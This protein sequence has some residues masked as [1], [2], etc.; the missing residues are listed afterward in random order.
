MLANAPQARCRMPTS[1]GGAAAAAA[2]SASLGVPGVDLRCAGRQ[3]EMGDAPPSLIL[4]AAAASIL[5]SI[6]PAGRPA[7][8]LWRWCC[9]VALLAPA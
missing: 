3:L 6:G 9:E 2:A 5:P 4:L 7:L 8:V 1:A